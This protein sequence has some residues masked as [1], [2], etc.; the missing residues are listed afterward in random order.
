MTGS[1]NNCEP[2]LLSCFSS[3]FVRLNGSCSAVFSSNVLAC[4]CCASLTAC[5]EK[6]GVAEAEMSLEKGH[7]HLSPSDFISLIV[8]QNLSRDPV[9]ARAIRKCAVK[10]GRT[11]ELFLKFAQSKSHDDCLPLALCPP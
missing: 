11:D 4:P 10:N 9:H 3:S 6:G 5:L 1:R 8:I 2:L 7:L